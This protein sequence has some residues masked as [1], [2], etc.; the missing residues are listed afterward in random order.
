MPG[1]DDDHE[2]AGRKFQAIK[3]DRDWLRRLIDER[4][5]AFADDPVEQ[6]DYRRTLI[7]LLVSQMVQ[8]L[9]G[10]DAEMRTRVDVLLAE[11]RKEM[12]DKTAQRK[13]IDRL[14]ID[15]GAAVDGAF[16]V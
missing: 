12:K 2:A 1:E 10:P 7:Y 3:A 4:A 9:Y 5:I 8:P 16:D 15:L 6:Q 13:R 11:L 14:L